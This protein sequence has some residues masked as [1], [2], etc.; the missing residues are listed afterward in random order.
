MSVR[1]P[2]PYFGT[3]AEPGFTSW[4]LAALPQAAAAENAA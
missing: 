2:P 4:R 3:T 1:E